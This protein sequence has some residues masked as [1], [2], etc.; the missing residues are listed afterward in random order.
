MIINSRPTHHN[1]L[2]PN[3]RETVLCNTWGLTLTPV[4]TALAME[5]ADIVAAILDPKKQDHFSYLTKKVRRRGGNTANI[6]R[7]RSAQRSRSKFWPIILQNPEPDNEIWLPHATRL[8]CHLRHKNLRRSQF[9]PR[10]RTAV[11]YIRNQHRHD[12]T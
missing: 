5:E 12:M 2:G 7:H 1:D 8:T 6:Y 9:H 11:S 10:P 3:E 4:A